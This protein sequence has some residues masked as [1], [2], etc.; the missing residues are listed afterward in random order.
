MER[1]DD[2]TLDYWKQAISMF[3]HTSITGGIGPVA[4]EILT[5]FTASCEPLIRTA[6][7]KIWV[8]APLEELGR[9]AVELGLVLE[10][11]S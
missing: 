6:E 7:F 2:D 11:V 1:A 5:P 3:R 10:A 8:E 9:R 4:H